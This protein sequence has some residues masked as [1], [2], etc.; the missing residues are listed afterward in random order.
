MKLKTSGSETF[1]I[2]GFAFNLLAG[3]QFFKRFRG[4]RLTTILY[5]DKILV[6]E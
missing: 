3:A 5:W 4:A 1:C 6:K 2:D